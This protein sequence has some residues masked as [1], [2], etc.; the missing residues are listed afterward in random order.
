MIDPVLKSTGLEEK[1]LNNDFNFNLT[2][3]R[4]SDI[5][6]KLHVLLLYFLIL[7][8]YFSILSPRSFL[9]NVSQNISFCTPWKVIEIWNNMRVSIPC[10][11]FHFWVTTPLTYFPTPTDTVS[12]AALRVKERCAPCVVTCERFRW[13]RMYACAR[14]R[15]RVSA[16]LCITVCG[17][18]GALFLIKWNTCTYYCSA[19]ERWDWFWSLRG[20]CFILYM[21]TCA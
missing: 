9:L 14:W 11:K 15:V 13:M 16:C 3:S 12:N 2:D 1:S 4:T 10:Q 8:L 20:M 19:R 21:C 5:A 18:V 17:W 6:R 7:F